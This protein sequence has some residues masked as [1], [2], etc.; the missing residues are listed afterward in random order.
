MPKCQNTKNTFDSF[1]NNSNYNNTIRSNNTYLIK[2][3]YSSNISNKNNTK[4][5]NCSGNN[6][7]TKTATRTRTTTA[8]KPS[9]TTPTVTNHVQGK[10]LK[11]T[12]SQQL[13]LTSPRLLISSNGFPPLPRKWLPPPLLPPHPAPSALARRTTLI[14]TI[15]KTVVVVFVGIKRDLSLC[16]HLRYH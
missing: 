12:P 14:L 5:H 2:N 15:D 16:L 10:L 3:N 9:A 6:N 8:A 4:I 1:N 7:N 13:R 11:D